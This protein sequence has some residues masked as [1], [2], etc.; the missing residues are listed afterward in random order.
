MMNEINKI[1]DKIFKKTFSHPENARA[2]LKLVLPPEIAQRVDFAAIEIDPNNYITTKFKEFLSDV[3]IKSRIK[4]RSD[5]QIPLDIYFILEHKTGCEMK[6]FI[7][8]LNYMLQ[9][10]QMD[11]DQNIPLRVIIPLVFYHGHEEWHIPQSFADQFDVD[12]EVKAFLL[13]YRYIL[14]DT[15]Q[16]D[17]FKQGHEEL[18]DNVYLLT[19]LALMKCA[20]HNDMETI[21]EIFKFWKRKGFIK[22]MNQILF[23]LTY[24]IETH[25]IGT[26]EI[27]TILEKSKIDGGKIIM[28]WAQQLREEGR[29]IGIDEGK[30]IG[31][32]EAKQIGWNEAKQI[33]WNE[34]KQ[35]GWNEGK[36]LEKIEIA[37]EMLKRH[38]DKKLI[39]EVT[40]LPIEKVESLTPES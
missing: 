35:M 8:V 27:K 19:S 10:W 29:L 4:S 9:E 22:D 33:G 30:R 16:W 20:Y 31:W 23:F 40:G 11:V 12:D 3:V 36:E 25:N 15:A 28:N 17:F 37:K 18:R 32:D 14:F 21:E 13:N 6:I 38:I 26:D 34:G 1:H 24:I 5:E 2:L 7:Q 39:S